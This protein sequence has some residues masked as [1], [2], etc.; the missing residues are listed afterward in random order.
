MIQL[1]A[2]SI[3]GF[4]ELSNESESYWPISLDGTWEARF[5][6]YGAMYSAYSA[7]P[8]S[9]ILLRDIDGS[10]ALELVCTRW[11][12]MLEL[13]T[14]DETS[15][16]DAYSPDHQVREF[17]LPG[18]GRRDVT[19]RVL[20]TK[21]DDALDRQIWL[22]RLLLENRPN[23]IERHTR[24]TPAI[25]F[26]DGDYGDFLV[27]DKDKPVSDSIKRLGCWGDLQ[28]SQFR[29]FVRAGT[30]VVDIGANI[31]HHT[32]VLSKLVGPSGRVLAF[33]P[34]R[35]VNRVM[36]SNLALNMC[37]NVD[38]FE[39]ALGAESGEAQMFP[40]D[41]ETE[42]WNVGGLSVASKDGELLFREGGLPIQIRRLD[43]IAEDT[44]IDFIKSDAQGFDFAAM[45]GA[46][47][48]L[49]RSRPILVSEVAPEAMRH[50]GYDYLDYYEFL[51]ELG[52]VLTDPDQPDFSAPA[53]QWSGDPLEEWDI[54]AIHRDKTEHLERLK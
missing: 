31:G 8:G 21:H 14:G 24:L 37:D 18:G 1:P 17:P 49:K 23:W 43:D 52:Y 32:V 11:S 53:R 33:E 29:R 39:F 45:Q 4:R 19:V 44:V 28:V 35:R 30:T 5:E 54:L 36:V 26:V 20:E 51:K 27:F 9:S 16:V 25:T 34:Q 12:G 42:E 15:V 40:L 7:S 46:A 47:E 13:S 41:Y 3:L 38:A 48:T 50:A 6:T 22:H 10:A 2:L